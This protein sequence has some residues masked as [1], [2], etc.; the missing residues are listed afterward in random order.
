MADP[1]KELREVAMLKLFDLIENIGILLIGVLLGWLLRSSGWP[2]LRVV[3]PEQ[4]QQIQPTPQI[5]IPGNQ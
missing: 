5:P 2:N 4:Y 3:T 1:G